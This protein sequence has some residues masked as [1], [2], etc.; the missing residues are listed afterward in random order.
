MKL[1]DF[2]KMTKADY[3]AYDTVFDA[4]VTVCFIEED[5]SNDNYEKFCIELMKKVDV[6][7]INGDDIIV[8]W[9]E[10][11]QNNM[12]KFRAFAMRHWAF[13]YEDDDDFIYEWIK[14]IH[15]YIA[16]YV[17]ESFYD[18]LVEFVKTLKG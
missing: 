18:T 11:I 4:V 5:E 9:T 7:E 16:G 3:D 8:K 12:E 13:E 6:E 15:Y 14:E 10:L 17:S 1:Y 2:M